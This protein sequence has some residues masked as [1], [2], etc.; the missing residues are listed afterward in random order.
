MEIGNTKHL[1][2]DVCFDFERRVMLVFLISYW[3]RFVLVLFHKSF[4]FVCNWWDFSVCEIGLHCNCCCYH[5]EFWIDNVE[6]LYC[7][8]EMN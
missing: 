8:F 7:Y 1:L 3:I 2:Y 5:I 4:S 6:C